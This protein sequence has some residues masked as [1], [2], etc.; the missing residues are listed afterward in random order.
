MGEGAVKEPDCNTGLEADN[1]Q[2]SKMVDTVARRPHLL[3]LHLQQ[4]PPTPGSRIC[5]HALSASGFWKQLSDPVGT[6]MESFRETLEGT[7]F[8]SPLTCDQ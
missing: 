7:G 4:L 6:V 3:L 2:G 1:E 8:V 5:S